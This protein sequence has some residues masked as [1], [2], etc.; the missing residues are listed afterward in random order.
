MARQITDMSQKLVLASG[1]AVRASLL[2]GA[3]LAFEI[4]VSGVDEAAIKAAY[5]EHKPDSGTFDGL[6]LALAEVKAKAVVANVD[7]AALVIGADQ[8]LVLDDKVFDKP[9]DRAEAKHNLMLFQGRSHCLVGGVVLVQ[10]GQTIWQHCET[11]TLKM[12]A[13]SEAFID[14]YLDAAGDEVLKSVGAYQLEGLGAHLFE[15]IEGDY[16]SILGLPLLPLMAALRAHGGLHH[17]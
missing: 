2:Y 3:G 12:R 7:A 4:A 16:F 6:A 17:V 14:A 5:Q 8:L 11:V 13:L 15:A 10:G 1:S 9:R